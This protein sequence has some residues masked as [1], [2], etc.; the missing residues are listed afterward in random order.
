MLEGA[1]RRCA[2]RETF[3]EKVT[4][5]LQLVAAISDLLCESFCSS[6]DKPDL[7]T[8][9]LHN[10]ELKASPGFNVQL[11]LKSEAS[12]ELTTTLPEAFERPPVSTPPQ[13]PC[14][15]ELQFDARY[16]WTYDTFF[17]PAELATCE[18]RG[19]FALL[20]I[21]AAS[22]QLS[23]AMVTLLEEA[24]CS[25]T[26]QGAKYARK[27]ATS[28][29]KGLARRGQRLVSPLRPSH[30]VRAAPK[31]G[32]RKPRKALLAPVLESEQ[33]VA[34]RESSLV[35]E[36]AQV[37]R[38]RGTEEVIGASQLEREPESEARTNYADVRSASEVVLAGGEAESERVTAETDN[39]FRAIEV[40]AASVTRGES[41]GAAETRGKKGAS[42]AVDDGP[43]ALGEIA[44]TGEQCSGALPE[45]RAAAE[46]RDLTGETARGERREAEASGGADKSPS[47]ELGS[48]VRAPSQ[49]GEADGTSL[50]VETARGPKDWEA[51][52]FGAEARPERETESS[53]SMLGMKSVSLSVRDVSN[54]YA[55]NADESDAAVCA[56]ADGKA[57]LGEEPS[58]SS[59]RAAERGGSLQEAE[60]WR[61]TGKEARRPLRENGRDESIVRSTTALEETDLETTK[62]GSGVTIWR[63][64]NDLP[65]RS[66][67]PLYFAEAKRFRRGYREVWS[68]GRKMLED[69][70]RRLESQLGKRMSGSKALHRFLREEFGETRE[71]SPNC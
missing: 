64:T 24:S 12:M 33:R 1:C 40:E 27:A 11:N 8:A 69:E 68:E 25:Y 15:K 39:P 50:I 41:R 52:D 21:L 10:I 65:K 44:A 3:A 43:D 20:P 55:G 59:L 61:E 62:R 26:V 45:R 9:R 49:A 4:T 6:K 67:G 23:V 60:N 71:M 47:R 46:E 38:V 2:E 53:S 31:Q 57:S 54:H 35:L 56:P 14:H 16:G 29:R 28:A 7:C 37:E 34:L 58:A 36:E 48:D 22:F 32:L 30:A 70:K 63:A 13:R 42:H 66:E 18:G 51:E 5:T 19:R 17:D